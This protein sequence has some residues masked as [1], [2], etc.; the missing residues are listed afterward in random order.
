MLGHSLLGCKKKQVQKDQ[1]TSGVGKEMEGNG[2][3]GK[4]K[5][6]DPVLGEK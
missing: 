3:T 4:A 5:E 6:S 1:S 2:A